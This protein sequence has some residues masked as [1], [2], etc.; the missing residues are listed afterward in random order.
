MKRHYYISDNLDELEAIERRLEHAGIPMPQIHVLS[1]DDA[2]VSAHH[3][4]EVEAV[5]RKD[6]VNGTARGAVVGLIGAATILSATWG[7]G[8][9]ANITWV[10]PI[11]LSIVVLGFCTWEGGFIG[12]QEPHED[13]ARFRDTLRAGKH[14]LVVDVSPRQEQI[15]RK[16]TGDYPRL[17]HAGEGEGAPGWFVG[18]RARFEQL[19]RG[20][21]WRPPYSHRTITAAQRTAS[22]SPPQR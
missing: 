22:S 9:A 15:L 16:V 20:T 19:I 21:A 14:V 1:D 17:A 11:F 6:V 13:F 10:P 8:I 12:I 4:N 3:L 7:S 18:A 5:L 2:E